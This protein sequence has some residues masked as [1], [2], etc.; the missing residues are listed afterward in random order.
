MRLGNSSSLK[1]KWLK[2]GFQRGSHMPLVGKPG[3]HLGLL[4]SARNSI[5]L[6]CHVLNLMNYSSLSM[7][8]DVSPFSRLLLGHPELQHSH[9]EQFPC[10]PFPVMSCWVE[11]MNAE[12]AAWN[13]L[14]VCNGFWFIMSYR[15]ISGNYTCISPHSAGN[16][17]PLA[18]RAPLTISCNWRKLTMF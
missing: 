18:L 13:S 7:F 17:P 3:T 15:A 6:A 12:K 11:W 2:L 14:T 1:K 4:E 16:S 5:L 9:C 8:P 10:T